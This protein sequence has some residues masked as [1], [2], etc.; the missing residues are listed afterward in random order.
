MN[1]LSETST[2]YG[3][4]TNSAYPALS[5]TSSAARTASAASSRNAKSSR[6]ANLSWRSRGALAR[7]LHRAQ[8]GERRRYVRQL[9]RHGRGPKLRESGLERLH[10]L[11]ARVEVLLDPPVGGRDVGSKS[12][13]VVRQERDAC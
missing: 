12:L 3:G 7:R 9:R 2:R 11:R 1:A 8:G 10:V 4:A 5:L 6:T 13:V